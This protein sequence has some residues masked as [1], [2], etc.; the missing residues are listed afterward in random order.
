MIRPQGPR[1][2][3][4][5]VAAAFTALAGLVGQ[6]G[7]AALDRTE[8]WRARL[9]GEMTVAI[10]PSDP[11][12]AETVRATEILAGTEG[13][14][15][16]R[17]RERTRVAELLAPWTAGARGPDLATLPRL[18]AVELDA[19]NPARRQDLAEALN[20][21]GVDA[22]VDDHQ[23]WRRTA[24]DF[25]HS[26][27]AGLL[28]ALM[29]CAS[30]LAA[31]GALAADQDF[32]LR[33]A[34]LQTRIQL[35]ETPLACLLSGVGPVARDLAAG[36]LVGGLAAAGLGVLSGLITSEIS[37]AGLIALAWR[38]VALVAVASLIAIVCALATAA[39]RIQELDP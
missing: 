7:M 32:A 27:A 38:L 4:L 39:R 15:D 9:A 11:A 31:I 28:A 21:A 29:L 12:G 20:A 5:V 26:A 8:G 3:V 19:R 37:S 13:V 25:R 18:I 30:G 10:R 33:R 14:A 34:A 35:G 16:V 23:G 22:V 36:A 6:A 1:L 17:A 24:A 2:A